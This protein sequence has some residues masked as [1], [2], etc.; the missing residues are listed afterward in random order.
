MRGSVLCAMPN[1]PDYSEYV[2]HFTSTASIEGDA[3]LSALSPLERLSNIHTEQRIRGTKKHW[4]LGGPSAAFT[5]C[6]WASRPTCAPRSSLQSRTMS[7]ARPS[8]RWFSAIAPEHGTLY[9]PFER[10]EGWKLLDGTVVDT[11][12][13]YA[14]SANGESPLTSN[15]RTTTS[16]SSSSRPLLTSPSCRKPSSRR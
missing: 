14:H 3:A 16:S 4:G 12:I 7:R 2:A 6:P 15:P 1:G 5:E 11:H 9:T 10:E 8:R 13:D